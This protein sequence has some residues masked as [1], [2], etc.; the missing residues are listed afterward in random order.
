M[1]LGCMTDLPCPCRKDMGGIGCCVKNEGDC[2]YQI[3]KESLRQEIKD[4][5]GK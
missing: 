3:L 4:K 2:E 1:N 5:E